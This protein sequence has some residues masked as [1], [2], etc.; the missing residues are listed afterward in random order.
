MIKKIIAAIDTH[1][2]SIEVIKEAMRQAQQ[3]QA[4]LSLVHVLEVP[5][6]LYG[7]WPSNFSVEEYEGLTKSSLEELIDK[8]GAKKD[9]LRILQGHRVHS[10]CDYANSES[11]DLIVVGTHT[12]KGFEKLLGSTANGIINHAKC[13]VLAVRGDLS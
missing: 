8:A 9:Q 5:A 12:K 4:T 3:E 6:V 10:F 7:D 2:W 1:D 11:A 13:N